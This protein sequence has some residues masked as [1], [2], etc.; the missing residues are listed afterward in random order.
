VNRKDRLLRELA[1]AG[2]LDRSPGPRRHRTPDTPEPEEPRRTGRTAL[3]WLAAIVLPVATTLAFVPFREDHAGTATVLLVAAV[4]LVALAGRTAPAVAAAVVAGGAYGLL[5]TEPYGE[6]RIT[7]ADDLITT[8]VL[9]ITAA[10]IATTQSRSNARART[11]DARSEQ[12]AALTD[13]VRAARQRTGDDLANLA[14]LRISHVLHAERC[15]WRPGYLGGASP[16]MSTSGG[17]E[18]W[19]SRLHPDA[20][21]LPRTFEIPVTADNRELGRFVIDAPDAHTISAEERRTA[22]TIAALVGVI[23]DRNPHPDTP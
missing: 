12:L 23:N 7:D 4:L 18:G 2:Q 21:T 16:T 6:P 17:F 3:V 1:L 5:L 13:L 11:S 14:A 9:L 8:M 20:R 22:L 10:V 15:E 19:P